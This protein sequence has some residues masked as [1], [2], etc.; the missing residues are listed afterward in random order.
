MALHRS[1][2]LLKRGLFYGFLLVEV[3]TAEAYYDPSAGQ[4]HKKTYCIV[5]S[6]RVY[7]S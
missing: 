2:S 7:L 6:S 3:N 5:K 4:E 1:V